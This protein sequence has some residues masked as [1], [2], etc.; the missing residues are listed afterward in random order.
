MALYSGAMEGE[1]ERNCRKAAYRKKLL[2]DRELESR[3][4]TVRR[5]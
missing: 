4:K 2:E 1:L 5:T 3:V